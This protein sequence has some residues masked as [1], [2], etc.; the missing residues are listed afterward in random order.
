MIAIEKMH[1]EDKVEVI[2]YLQK[3]GVFL[4]KGAI[5][6]VAKRLN[7]FRYTLHNYLSEIKPEKSIKII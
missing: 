4:V 3:R 5:E 2:R 1:K 6:K 7:V